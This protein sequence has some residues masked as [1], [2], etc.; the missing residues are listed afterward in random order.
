MRPGKYMYYNV[1]DQVL[2]ISPASMGHQPV[3]KSYTSVKEQASKTHHMQSRFARALHGFLEMVHTPS[4]R[5]SIL[6]LNLIVEI[7][8]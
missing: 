7:H 5:F 3:D 6:Y 1:S 2:Q 4:G 8:L